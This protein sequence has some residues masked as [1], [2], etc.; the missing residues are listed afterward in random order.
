MKA[1][2][3][4]ANIQELAGFLRK[5]MNHHVFRGIT[6]VPEELTKMFDNLR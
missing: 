5:E 4:G 1:V 2:E 6:L 3:G